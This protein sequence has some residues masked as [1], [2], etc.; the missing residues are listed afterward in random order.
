MEFLEQLITVD[1]VGGGK[2][3]TV[4][5]SRGAMEETVLS[6]KAGKL[7]S[8]DLLLCES[9]EEGRLGTVGSG[10]SSSTSLSLS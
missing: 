6:I 7:S 5:V 10:I 2:A 4:S 1:P 9:S 8:V 3:L